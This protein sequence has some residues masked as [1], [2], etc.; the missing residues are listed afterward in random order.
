MFLKWHSF[1]F[2]SSEFEWRNVLNPK[3]LLRCNHC[4]DW[5]TTCD[6]TPSADMHICRTVKTDATVNHWQNHKVS[7][8]RHSLSYKWKITWHSVPALGS[9]AFSP[10]FKGK[11]EGLQGSTCLPKPLVTAWVEQNLVF[12]ENCTKQAENILDA[13]NKKTRRRNEWGI[14][15]NVT[16]EFWQIIHPAVVVLYI[17]N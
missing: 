12:C 1:S 15:W 3:I 6:G 13:W 10:V 17:M 7:P 8:S 11:H 5:Y 16:A 14:C 4:Y 2:I 9:K